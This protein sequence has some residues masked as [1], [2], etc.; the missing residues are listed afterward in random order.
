MIYKNAEISPDGLYRY[1]L[2]REWSIGKRFLT[3]VMLN[4]STADAE[5]DDA[6]IRVCCGRAKLLNFHGILVLNL[7]ALRT[8]NPKDLYNHSDPIGPKNNYYIINQL[9]ELHNY[10]APIIVAWGNHGELNNRNKE[11]IELAKEYKVNML[12]L[13]ITKKGQPSHPL[14]ISYEKKLIPYG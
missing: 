1:T 13:K 10:N 6:T 11:F 7:F 14:R 2:T 12:A 3:Y 9:K 8:T 4:P 5:I